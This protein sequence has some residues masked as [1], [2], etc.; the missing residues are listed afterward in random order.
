MAGRSQKYT[1]RFEADVSGAKQSL[2][3]LNKAL[4]A[5]VRNS[6]G[7][8]LNLSFKDAAVSAQQLKN[9]LND[10][11]NVDTGK[12]NFSKF[13]S[14]L[15][16][17]NTDLNT[18]I[19]NLTRV[20]DVGRTAI[21]RLGTSLSSA[22]IPVKKLSGALGS[23]VDTFSHTVKWTLASNFLRG[24][25]GAYNSAM[26][27]AENLNKTLTSIQQVSNL[28]LAD[29]QKFTTQANS[30]AK[31]LS[32]TTKQYA[33]ASLIYFQQGDS[34]E[35]A[36][37]KAEITL[38]ATNSAFSA[39]AQE[40]S[41]MLTATWN[42]YQVSA[43][44]LEHYVDVM[45]ALG[46]N[47][48]TSLEEIS[49]ALQKVA[50]TANVT[51]VSMEKMSSMI[52]TVSSTTR[53][54][55]QVVGTAFNT[56]LGRISSLK[57]GETLE[58][59]VTLTKYTQALQQIGVSVLDASGELR[60]MGTVI[61]EIGDK[62]S[63]M[64][65]AQQSALA[66]T[67][68]GVRQYTNLMALFNNWDKYKAN[69]QIAN[70]SNGQ[71]QKMQDI[72]AN[73]WEGAAKRSRAAVEELYEVL[74]DDQAI[75]K[76]KNGIA[77]ITE[78]I[79]KLVKGLGG[80]PGIIFMVG[81]SLNNA[82]GDKIATKI[83][84]L[85]E[86]AYAFGDFFKQGGEQVTKESFRSSVWQIL[87]GKY[88]GLQQRQQ[89][90]GLQQLGL[91]SRRAVA[92]TD[93]AT[94][95]ALYGQQGNLYNA[96]AGIL[97][98]RNPDG[99]L[100]KRMTTLQ[101]STAMQANSRELQA[102]EASINAR[103]GYISDRNHV[104]KDELSKPEKIDFGG[105]GLAK[106]SMKLDTIVDRRKAFDEAM[107]QYAGVTGLKNS[108]LAQQR[109]MYRIAMMPRSVP[110][111]SAAKDAA[112]EAFFANQI[113]Q[114]KVMEETKN[115][116]EQLYGKEN[117][118]FM[119]DVTPAE[120][121]ILAGWKE[122]NIYS[123]ASAIDDLVDK[124]PTFD[125]RETQ[126]RVQE[127]ATLGLKGV[128]KGDSKLSQDFLDTLKTY[129]SSDKTDA[130]VEKVLSFLQTNQKDL[131]IGET[132]ELAKQKE[133]AH[134]TVLTTQ[135][136][137]REHYMNVGRGLHGS[138]GKADLAEI[139]R[140]IKKTETFQEK[141][142]S[143]NQ[144]FGTIGQT[145][146][147]AGLAAG[148]GITAVNSAFDALKTDS[149]EQKFSAATNIVTGFAQSMS[150]GIWG[151]AAYGIAAGIT[152]IVKI[153]DNDRLDKL[154]KAKEEAQRLEN[155]A[156]QAIENSNKTLKLDTQYQALKSQIES[157][158]ITQNEYQQSLL[159]TADALGIQSA[160]VLA[161]QGNY[162]G[163]EEQIQNTIKIQEEANAR[164]AR[165]ALTNYEQGFHS[166][167]MAQDD[168]SPLSLKYD[169]NKGYVVLDLLQSLRQ[170]L[171]YNNT[172]YAKD[173]V[174][175][176]ELQQEIFQALGIDSEPFVYTFRGQSNL[177]LAKLLGGSI[178][179]DKNS[180][181]L[182]REDDL[183]LG[184]SPN[185]VMNLYFRGRMIE[186]QAKNL[187]TNT[188][189]GAYL[190][191][192]VSDQ[193]WSDY[194]SDLS[195][196]VEPMLKLQDSVRRSEGQITLR[197]KDI[198]A[199]EFDASKRQELEN[200]F[201]EQWGITEGTD[202]LLAQRARETA[203]DIIDTYV[204]NL[205][206][207]GA[208]AVTLAKTR[209][210][211]YEK[212]RK[213]A[214][215]MGIESNLPNINSEIWD[216]TDSAAL[217][218]YP[219]S[220]NAD[221][222]AQTLKN[223]KMI[224]TGR[225]AIKNSWNLNNQNFNVESSLLSLYDIAE[226]SGFD[227]LNG[228]SKTDITKMNKEMQIDLYSRIIEHF[229]E[230]LDD[231]EFI[232]DFKTGSSDLAKIVN[233]V[234]DKMFTEEMS[235]LTDIASIMQKKTGN[236]YNFTD[237]T[238]RNTAIEL[239]QSDISNM[240]AEERAE[241][242]TDEQITSIDN[243]YKSFIDLKNIQIPDLF[244]P[245]AQSTTQLMTNV[246]TLMG[247]EL[248]PTK[249]GKDTL[250]SMLNV[251]KTFGYS[252]TDWLDMSDL[253]RQKAQLEMINQEII[254]LKNSA[255]ASK[256][257]TEIKLLE[258]QAESLSKEINE[259]DFSHLESEI[260]AIKEKWDE[261]REAA[262]SALEI[263][264]KNIGSNTQ[265]DFTDIEKLRQ[266]LLNAG[267]E[268][269]R[270]A[271]ILTRLQQI[272]NSGEKVNHE[273]VWAQIMA[274]TEAALVNVSS[275]AAEKK[276]YEN[277]VSE[278]EIKN[279][280]ASKAVITPNPIPVE[281]HAEEVSAEGTEVTDVEE[282]QVHADQVS[283]EGVEVTEIDQPVVEVESLTANF[284]EIGEMPE[285][286][287]A[288][289]ILKAR[290][291]VAIQN[292]PKGTPVDVILQAVTD[293]N[294]KTDIENQLNSI[295]KDGQV[296]YDCNVT[297]HYIEGNPQ[298]LIDALNPGEKQIKVVFKEATESA[299]PSGSYMYDPN[300]KADAFA[301]K[302]NAWND[303]TYNT[304]LTHFINMNSQN[305]SEAILADKERVMKAVASWRNDQGE[306]IATQAQMQQDA[307][308]L[309]NSFMSYISS[310]DTEIRQI[311]A[312]LLIGLEAGLR[313]AGVSIDWNATLGSLGLSEQI[314]AAFKN[315]L[316]IHSPS[317]LTMALA[318]FLIEGLQVG[319]DKAIASYEPSV[320]GLS[321]KFE[322]A[323][324]Q[325]LSNK[326]D[327]EKIWNGF[328]D[329]AIESEDQIQATSTA[330]Q[331]FTSWTAEQEKEFWKTKAWNNSDNTA[332]TPWEKYHINKAV[333]QVE[334]EFG[335]N[336]DDI[337][338]GEKLDDAIKRAKEII[339]ENFRNL[340][341]D[342]EA[343]WATIRK[344][345]SDGLVQ[346]FNDADVQK[347]YYDS[348]TK[349]FSAIAT[350]R[351]QLWSHESIMDG[352]MDDAE[353]LAEIYK[354]LTEAG[355]SF[356]EIA[357]YIQDPNASM[358][359]LQFR[360]Y[361]PS[362]ALRGDNR[363]FRTDGNNRIIDTT[364]Q[365]YSA[366]REA[367]FKEMLTGDTGIASKYIAEM[368]NKNEA[369][370]AAVQ[371]Q[372]DKEY[373]NFFQENN[374]VIEIKA[375]TDIA[376]LINLLLGGSNGADW[377][378]KTAATL[379]YQNEEDMKQGMYVARAE[380][381]ANTYKSQA[382]E[383]NEYREMLGISKETLTEFT[384]AQV[385]QGKV[386]GET[387]IEQERAAASLYRM[388]R[389]MTTAKKSANKLYKELQKC[390]KAGSDTTEVFNNLRDMYADVF[391]L[392]D[393]EAEKLSDPFLESEKNIKLLTKA[394]K[395][396]EKAW[397][398]LTRNAAD[399]IMTLKNASD[400]VVDEN[401]VKTT[402][403]NMMSDIQKWL[404]SKNL[405]VGA[406]ID[407]SAFLSQCEKLIN[408]C[409]NTADEASS[410]LSTLG[411]DATIE[412]HTA[413]VPKS[414][415]HYAPEGQISIPIYDAKGNVTYQTATPTGSMSVAS[416]MAEFK[417]FTIKGAKSNANV[418]TR[419]AG[420]SGGGGGGG[421][422]K[423]K[424]DYKDP[425]KEKERYHQINQQIGLQDKKLNRLS[426]L[427]ERAYGGKYLKSMNQEIDALKE[428]NKLYEEKLR[429]V[430][431]N[432]KAEEAE[433][434]LLGATFA[435][436]GTLDYEAYM[437]NI[438]AEYNDAVDVFNASKQEDDD[439]ET[440]KEAEKL[441]DKRKKLMED[442]EEDLN[443]IEELNNNILEQ[444]N[445]ISQNILEGIQYKLDLKV[446]LND[447]DIKYLQYIRERW[448]DT[449]TAAGKSMGALLEEEKLYEKNLSALAE[450]KNEADRQHAAGELFD[451]DYVEALKA[452]NEK[453]LEFAKN[454]QDTAK[455]V[456]ETY[457]NMLDKAN[458]ELQKHISVLSHTNEIVDQY[459]NMM[460]LMGRG[461][462]YRKMAEMYK[463]Q[464]NSINAN[465]EAQKQYVDTLKEAKERLDYM[466]ESAGGYNEV[467][468][469]IREE[470]DI[471]VQKIAEG[472]TELNNLTQ[473]SLEKAKEMFK[474]TC[475]EII[476][477]FDE[478]LF[479][480]KDG[481]TRMESDYQYY[482]K[483]QERY[484]STAKEL[485]EVSK[486]NRQIEASIRDATT[487]Q[488]KERLKMLQQE[489]KLKSESG[490]L[491]EYDAQMLELQYKYA[492]ALQAVEDKANTKSV[493]RLTRDDNG[494][495]GY[496]YTAD[497]NEIDKANQ[498]LED[499]LQQIN[500]LAANRQESLVQERLS[501]ERE[502]RE[503]LQSIL[504]DES[505]S[506]EEQ[507][508]RM[509]E[510]TQRHAENLQYIQEQYQNAQYA[511][512][513]NQGV[514]QERYKST[515]LA[516]T[517][518][519][520]DQMN[521]S[522]QE[523]ISRTTAYTDY[524]SALFTQG[525]DIYEAFQQYK[526]DF[527][528]VETISG[529]SWDSMT[530]S[531]EEYNKQNDEAVE[532]IATVADQ[533]QTTIGSVLDATTAW[534]EHANTIAQVTAQY[535]AL[536]LA[537][538]SAIRGT[539]GDEF[540]GEDITSIVHRVQNS[541]ATG[542]LVDYTGLAWVDG[543]K[544]RPELMLNANDTVN[545]LHAVDTV[546][547]LDT[548]WQSIYNQLTQNAYGM[549][550]SMN[551]LFTPHSVH[552][553]QGELEQNVHITAE[554]PNATDRVEIDAAFNDLIN[555]AS[556]YANRK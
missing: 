384:D 8:K 137:N 302:K 318:P 550:Y 534:V 113:N 554:F 110:G 76:V 352:L 527:G 331:K 481:L 3:E 385:R 257:E 213:S 129:Q 327:L 505:L 317:T 114:N 143:V 215:I 358:D 350:A 42:A 51:G 324:L 32:T 192:L 287:Q 442:Y 30:M 321:G 197:N 101:R 22:E 297:I 359:R 203:R 337:I 175:S 484:L 78:A 348:W 397:D 59:G 415:V 469:L 452:V 252:L 434:R 460:K 130:D 333:T 224:S 292:I 207:E 127:I 306:I 208:A 262:Q 467:S 494:N 151:M 355:M 413:V 24:I 33:D 231:P 65:V 255:D 379:G 236:I 298:L 196:L 423:K 323:F 249:W 542:G 312:Y 214:K 288:D 330:N 201:L 265:M 544:T 402:I 156:N 21:N 316:G 15:N 10:A 260:D 515:I 261:T 428:Q 93:D 454:L 445:K 206:A 303:A 14:N 2:S 123:T 6:N 97:L 239:L 501:L 109:E 48:A 166:T 124:A 546:R 429:Q 99:S 71:L 173:N 62:W 347:K 409:A 133:K 533:L 210:T 513:Y 92:H 492:L 368:M 79:T 482:Q 13:T 349:T 121:A 396:N 187:G 528:I 411:V 374:G 322:A 399:D 341:G 440:L 17:A 276:S 274:A 56:V 171:S 154:Q 448:A 19:R 9:S 540:A 470:W 57:L 131:T 315:A 416:D 5:V 472:E 40:M 194:M 404:D 25:Q 136:N 73:S 1:I 112:I 422:K 372:M 211:N 160:K 344:T 435:S 439:Q 88:V 295:F 219:S 289:V 294:N 516:N 394:A 512:I 532:K 495:Y 43:D 223:Q 549:L 309:V 490:R 339:D 34:A 176:K 45:A 90:Y 120:V 449:F 451:N 466:I 64:S 326:H 157:G 369:A 480:Q 84:Q 245:M 222:I 325:E 485:Y 427:K 238:Q 332:M 510:L 555:L 58:D 408:L 552:G 503:G 363:F 199:A 216:Y 465:I 142:Q 87:S 471:T 433:L 66:S 209:T 4:N 390:K 414:S 164:E 499:V 395:G 498:E 335:I 96:Q 263:I 338:N 105:W 67:I 476:S 233:D 145:A 351:K 258:E 538:A 117:A 220:V 389:G 161:L 443:L 290:D 455:E 69:L 83:G 107:K 237:P 18:V 474:N 461:T 293:E 41:Q 98:N 115:Y 406:E 437:D 518:L 536:A 517:G 280:D 279:I 204:T 177:F 244:E 487:Q 52:A 125:Q 388:D 473:S 139:E 111:G 382:A 193:S 200:E 103:E 502:Y 524:L 26:S 185:D 179:T 273:Q 417:Y 28:T 227:G 296:S 500:E 361:D 55:A 190:T 489:I 85:G 31:A 370:R 54:S 340:D 275:I 184:T 545:L 172:N 410:A 186:E 44:Q 328:F 497:Q 162:Q 453:S 398:E 150:G 457:A 77:D 266:D 202:A 281:A 541:Y 269:E 168:K 285:D 553:E 72:Y 152:A 420:S 418:K 458:E 483:E 421:G 35:M 307:Q 522:M 412:E 163:L 46:A 405:K 354:T 148:R 446:E 300:N 478:V 174:I 432:I 304:N 254:K 284:Q 178:D 235:G 353:S 278:S 146:M 60:D 188:K 228:I 507:M 180:Y 320:K 441:Y 38:K 530:A 514:I 128:I 106:T 392:T 525:G 431:A 159:A 282:A 7:N 493:V 537:A 259:I 191:K 346:L 268:G 37:K 529:N 336:W 80:L 313:Q 226:F 523:V 247:M 195:A 548:D 511:L 425:S 362:M 403:D 134:K 89:G 543:T 491:T 367:E 319:L 189:A 11:M 373:D 342:L 135:G 407:D 444:Q 477:K 70:N 165:Q 241:I 132:S 526:K 212:A 49:G 248:D 256:N 519:I 29:M 551:G 50:S 277:L 181:Y 91:Q 122:Q 144:K 153:I 301:A 272:G 447:R 504:D 357:A 364:W 381:D 419:K 169:E 155:E 16:A 251:L 232:Q 47:T 267:V 182:G 118:A 81:Q 27:Y 464:F 20:G 456:K 366:N 376:A 23:L 243:F 198:N 100:A 531:L 264:S 556:Q 496:Q 479:K 242:L 74:I 286:T 391:D 400:E 234:M 167:Y 221:Q 547:T 520:Q 521:M 371:T 387:R 39:T 140:G 119:G 218:K 386:V 343:A 36:A 377:L 170:N 360:N 305:T 53:Q 240:D 314:I 291:D 283:A 141:L 438:I 488:S 378:K 94:L 63:S 102:L 535:E 426:T 149:L 299:N 246:Q 158:A 270:V 225:G 468:D 345:W 463:V 271:T 486:L 424:N 310:E 250:D 506:H 86:K 383:L 436:D 116:R 253:D 329:E 183:K 450:A 12:L 95:K 459:L 334:E 375:D 356:D 509:I 61:E 229:K 126:M 68:G 230:S 75:I 82:F 205:G 147:T 508:E 380:Q 365:Q 138:E 308:N 104:Y 539:A 401:G 430:N 108:A 311:G 462:D 393:Q 475:D 217:F